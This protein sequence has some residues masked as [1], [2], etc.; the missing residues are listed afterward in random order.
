[1]SDLAQNSS[2]LFGKNT[3]TDHYNGVTTKHIENRTPP[4]KKL[5]H[6]IYHNKLS[7]NKAA[8]KDEYWPEIRRTHSWRPD[9]VFIYWDPL[10]V[11][12]VF[13]RHLTLKMVRMENQLV[14]F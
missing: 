4:P 7:T 14:F 2:P 6:K 11:R 5:T 1:M 3:N 13:F 12:T 8:C 10:R 9:N